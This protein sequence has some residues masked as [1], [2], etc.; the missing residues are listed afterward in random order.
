MNYKSDEK[1]WI[2]EA[3]EEWAE[4][5]REKCHKA[6]MDCNT[7]GH[8]LCIYKPKGGEKDVRQN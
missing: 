8:K 2:K 4:H 5:T 3:E 6:G 7:C 1:S